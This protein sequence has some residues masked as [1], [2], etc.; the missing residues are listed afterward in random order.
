MHEFLHLNLNTIEFLLYL[1]K[2]H[3][4]FQIGFIS[5]F[6]KA[7]SYIFFYEINGKWFVICYQFLWA[8]PTNLSMINPNWVEY[9]FRN[10]NFIRKV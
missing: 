1:E 3:L 4:F 8:F 2:K 10:F 6:W 7:F 5:Y 9:D